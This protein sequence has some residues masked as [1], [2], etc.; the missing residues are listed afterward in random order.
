M[1]IYSKIKLIFIH[2]TITS[3]TMQAE[4]STLL[5]EVTKIK[6]VFLGDSAV[7]KTSILSHICNGTFS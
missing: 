5:N 7:G 4:E 6:I 3:I 2:I 1:P